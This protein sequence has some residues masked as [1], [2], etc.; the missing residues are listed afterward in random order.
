MTV[1]EELAARGRAACERRTWGDACRWFAAADERSAL[2]AEDLDRFG[3]AAYLTDRVEVS[4]AVWERAFRAFVERGE[5]A[6]AVRCAFWLGL[7]LVLRGEHARGGAWLVRAQRALGETPPDCPE[8]G[9]LRFPAALRAMQDDPGRASALF[10]EIGTI[11]QRFADPDLTALSRLGRGQALVLMG[12]VTRGAVLLDEAMLAVTTG[13][14][15]VLAAGIVYCA[16]IKTCHQAFDLR[17]AQEWTAALHRWCAGQQDLKPFRGQCLVHRSEILQL[18]GEWAEAM[19]EVRHAGEF[20][21]DVPG[22]PVQGMALYQQG[23][24]LR[25]RGEFARA[26]DAYLK[27]SVWGHAMQPGLAL[28]RLAQGRARDAVAAM[29]RVIDETQGPGERARVLAAYVEI[30]LATDDVPAARAAADEL[31]AIAEGFDAPYLWAVVGY[32]DGS[33]LMAEDDPA[34][35]AAALY[36]VKAGWQELDAPYEVARTGLLLGCACARLGDR[37]TAAMEWAAARSVFERLGAAPD[38]VRLGELASAVPPAGGLT[39]R[40]LEVLSLVAAGRTNR[41]IAA[42]LVISEHTAR[43]HVQNIFAKLGISSRAAATAYAYR[44]KLV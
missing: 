3:V 22:D 2:A 5:T 24:L 19:S 8:Q 18:R 11:A 12:E 16:V 34:A 27:A 17:R 26:E 1:A 36:R 13:E 38:L 31:T 9:Y 14:V 23:E 33:V 30:A 21:A 40:E 32:A 37:D 39:R 35:A 29:H 42:R 44:H 7:T 20:L 10:E 6:R 25:L 15:S 43:R 28:L 41:E 4:A